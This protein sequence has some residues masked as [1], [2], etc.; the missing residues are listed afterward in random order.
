MSLSF[1][2]GEEKR[3]HHFRRVRR[4]SLSA[5]VSTTVSGGAVTDGFYRDETEKGK[6]SGRK[7]HLGIDVSLSRGGDGSYN[8]VRRGTPVHI[9]VL[10]TIKIGDL[11]AVKAYNKKTDTKLAGLGID[12]TGDAELAEA[13]IKTQP[14]EPKDGDSYG[15]IVGVACHY[16]YTKQEG[17]E[18]YFTLYLEYLHLITEKYLAKN[19]AGKIASPDEWKAT[20]KPYGFGPDIINNAR[21]QKDAFSGSALRVAGYLGAT[22]FPHVHI[23]AAYQPGKVEYARDIRFDPQVMIY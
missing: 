2:I 3:R 16:K 13:V 1:Q 17:T 21:W 8:D 18:G 9:V 14:W 4:M 19:S 6:G 23:Q 22:Q 11:N 7:Q 20:G 15:G 10:T 5:S 12:G